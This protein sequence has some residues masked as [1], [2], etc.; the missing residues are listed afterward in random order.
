[1]EFIGMLIIA[2]SNLVQDSY[3]RTQTDVAL[4]FKTKCIERVVTCAESTVRSAAVKD[5]EYLKCAR[6]IKKEIE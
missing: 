5:L 1:M 6:E 4:K 3:N 2:C